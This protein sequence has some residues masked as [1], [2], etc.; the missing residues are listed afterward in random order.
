M[1][2]TSGVRAPRAQ[3]MIGGQSFCV[4]SAAVNQEATR[5]SSTMFAS[6]ALNTFPGGDA[7]LAGL[8][9][10]KG[11]VSIDGVS[12]CDGEWDSATI[13]YDGTVVT[14]TRRDSSTSL[15]ERKSSEKFNNQT[16]S[17]IVKTVAKRNNLQVQADQLPLLAGKLF[18]ID[19]AKLTDGV[20]D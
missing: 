1:A 7:F 15:H 20:S 4:L 9:D 8:S 17:D 10:N 2:I 12:L 14:L 13:G 6:C 18:Q 3:V 11:S 16:R 5:R 19:W